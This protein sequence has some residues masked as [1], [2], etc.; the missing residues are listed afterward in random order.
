MEIVAI[1]IAVLVVAGLVLML[2]TRR[3]EAKRAELREE[4][5]RHREESRVRSARADRAAAE[6]EELA[7]KAERER[8]FAR[9]KAATAKEL[10][11]DMRR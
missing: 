6:A 11:P 1:V 3:R 4:A 7:A 10:D 5:H 2:G 9:D 8:R